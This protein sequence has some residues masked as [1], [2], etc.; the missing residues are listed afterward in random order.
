MFKADLRPDRIARDI[1]LL[2]QTKIIPGETLLFLNEILQT[3]F[4]PES[5][6]QFP[7]KMKDAHFCLSLVSC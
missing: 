2:I 3:F 6:N 5:A 4:H 7:C 1:S